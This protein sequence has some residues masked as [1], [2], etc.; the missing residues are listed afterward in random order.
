MIASIRW[1]RA[2]GFLFA[3]G[4]AA[5][6]ETPAPPPDPLAPRPV[7]EKR[8]W[9]VEHE[10]RSLGRVAELE[11][12]DPSGPVT[13]FHVETPGGQWVGWIDG[14]GRVYQRVPFEDDDVFRGVHSME[15]A[16]ALLYEVE[17]PL[18]LVLVEEG[19]AVSSPDGGRVRDA[20]FDR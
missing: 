12:Q 9:Q 3:A 17:P 19:G 5:A 20:A 6:C 8:S 2:V 13:R 10:G 15:K 18:R 11:I 4:L 16:V 14:Q 1:R 7:V